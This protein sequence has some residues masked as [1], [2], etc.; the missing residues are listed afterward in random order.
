MPDEKADDLRATAE[1]IAEDAGRL[2]QIE[3][4]K[5][6]LDPADPRLL[7]LADEAARIGEEVAIK[8]S[9]EKELALDASGA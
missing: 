5:L 8:T 2:K 6:E 9:I 1:S 4:A 3:E 7:A